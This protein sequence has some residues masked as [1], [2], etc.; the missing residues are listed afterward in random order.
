MHEWQML[1]VVFSRLMDSGMI[2][3]RQVERMY[4][5]AK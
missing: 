4:E 2:A 3:I 5:S 1:F